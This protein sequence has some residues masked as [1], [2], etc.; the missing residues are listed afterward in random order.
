MIGVYIGGPILVSLVT[1][2]I[3]RLLGYQ[4][5]EAGSKPYF[6]LGFNIGELLCCFS[7]AAVYSVITVP[8][9]ILALVLFKAHIKRKRV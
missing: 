7:L 3:C 1:L 2:A 4:P 8:T 6:V 5:D 9:G